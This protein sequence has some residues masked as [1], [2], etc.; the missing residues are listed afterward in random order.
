VSKRQTPR[1]RRGVPHGA[2][3]A[4]G[5]IAY[6]T[7]GDADLARSQWPGHDQTIR[8][9]RCRR[10]CLYHLGHLPEAVRRGA[11]TIGE[12]LHPPT[13]VGLL[14]KRQ[15]RVLAVIADHI[16]EHGFPPSPGEVCG[17]A[18]VESPAAVEQVL[19]VLERKGWIR[20][21]PGH[22]LTLLAPLITRSVY[23]PEAGDAA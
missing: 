18:R 12:Y 17:P 14:T 9:Y 13:G 3:N 22:G 19:S 21:D 16:R 15:R 10:C 8:A 5:K 6:H 2:T 4:C 23:R 20:R 1:A 11:V 7:R